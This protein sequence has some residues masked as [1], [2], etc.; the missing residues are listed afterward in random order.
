M[1]PTEVYNHLEEKDEILKL[2]AAIEKEDRKMVL[3]KGQIKFT[4]LGTSFL[5]SCTATTKQ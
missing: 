4:H 1:T 2:K 5:E 3:E